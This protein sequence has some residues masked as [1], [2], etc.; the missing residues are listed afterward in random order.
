[1]GS[2]WHEYNLRQIEPFIVLS[3]PFAY[4]TYYKARKQAILKVIELIKNNNL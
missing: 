3:R 4:Q 2:E 1:M